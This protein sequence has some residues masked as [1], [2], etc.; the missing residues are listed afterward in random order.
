MNIEFQI[1]G[2]SEGPVYRWF[3]VPPGYHDCGWRFLCSPRRCE[4]TLQLHAEPL[5]GEVRSRATASFPPIAAN[6][7]SRGVP[8]GR[9]SICG[10]NHPGT[11]RLLLHRGLNTAKS[12]CGE[13]GRRRGFQSEFWEAPQKYQ[14]WRK[15]NPKAGLPDRIC[16]CSHPPIATAPLRRLDASALNVEC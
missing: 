13:A 8:S 12:R 1:T 9:S 2:K 15:K 3:S 7:G 10:Q 14:L 6:G 11:L 5:I 16:A 4:L